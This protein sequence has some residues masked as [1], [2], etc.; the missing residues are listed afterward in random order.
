MERAVF[1][2]PLRGGFERFGQLARGGQRL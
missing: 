1:D 2:Q